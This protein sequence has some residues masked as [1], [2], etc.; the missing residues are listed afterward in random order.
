MTGIEKNYSTIEKEALVMIYVNNKYC[1][2]LLPEIILPS[3]WIIK[4]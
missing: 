1:H 2:Y 4:L 3:L